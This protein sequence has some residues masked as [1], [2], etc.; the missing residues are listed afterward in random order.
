MELCECSVED[1]LQNYLE[2]S[3]QSNNPNTTNSSNTDTSGGMR[4][5][6]LYPFKLEDI[7]NIVRDMLHAVAF[8]HW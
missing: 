5:P 1:I 3:V 2:H 7:H 8:L 6:Q 4:A